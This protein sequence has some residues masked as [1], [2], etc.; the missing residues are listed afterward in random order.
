[1]D[2]KEQNV[3]NVVVNV[4]PNPASNQITVESDGVMKTIFLFRLTGKSVLEVYPDATTQSINL[5]GVES[6]VYLMNILMENGSVL[7]KKI[8]VSN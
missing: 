3:N 6:G 1:M 2:I 8:I 5:S 7:P 4:F